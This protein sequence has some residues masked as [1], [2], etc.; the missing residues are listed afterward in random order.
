MVGE[1][2]Q[3]LH[4]SASSRADQ[5]VDFVDLADHGRPAFRRDGPVTR[6]WRW[7]DRWGD[8]EIG[9]GHPNPAP[10]T[11]PR[12]GPSSRGGSPKT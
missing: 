7:A 12:H 11:P 2:R 9:A 1:E 4:L 6:R 5:R 3:A 10:N 8:G